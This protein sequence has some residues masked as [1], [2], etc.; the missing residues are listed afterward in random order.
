[1]F[2]IFLKKKTKKHHNKTPNTTSVKTVIPKGTQRRPLTN[3][4]SQ[5]LFP[6]ILI[7]SRLDLKVFHEL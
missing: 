4:Q 7:A 6:P 5:L 1:M 3:G 2:S